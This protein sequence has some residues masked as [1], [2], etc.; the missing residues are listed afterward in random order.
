MKRWN[1]RTWERRRSYSGGG[2]EE[3]LLGGSLKLPFSIFLDNEGA[4]LWGPLFLLVI[5]PLIFGD[6]GYLRFFFLSFSLCRHRPCFCLCFC[7]LSFPLPSLKNAIFFF[8][9]K[10][11]INVKKWIKGHDLDFVFTVKIEQSLVGS[12][13]LY[14]STCLLVLFF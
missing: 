4:R 6:R 5:W 12:C 14:V 11:P 2:G 1:Q 9:V 13:G 10:N 7:N 8:G 3:A